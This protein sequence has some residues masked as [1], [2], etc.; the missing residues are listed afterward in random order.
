MT[1]RSTRRRN[2]DYLAAL[3]S[4]LR[5]DAATATRVNAALDER[6]VEAMARHPDRVSR[7]DVSSPARSDRRPGARQVRCLV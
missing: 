5:G 1:I 7:D 3:A 2:R 6:L 4:L